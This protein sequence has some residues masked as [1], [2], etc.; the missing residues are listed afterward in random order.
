MTITDDILNQLRYRSESVDLDFKQAQYRFIGA[1]DHEKSELLKD[2]LA[3]ANS[4][5]EGTGYILIGFKDCSPNPAQVT[6]ISSDDHIDDAQL[7]QFVNSKVKPAL[8]FKYE[9]KMFEEK[10]VAVI[11]I[12]KQ[13]RPFSIETQY[14]KVRSNVVYVRRGSATVEASLAE[15]ISMGSAESRPSDGQISIEVL[16]R[17][18]EPQSLTQNLQFLT[19]EEIPNFS[20]PYTG[21]DITSLVKNI[22]VAANSDYY[23][24]L[25]NYA[26]LHLGSIYLKFKIRNQS[27][28]SLRDFK[29]EL[30]I[31]SL[32]V[33]YK[34]IE[35]ARFPDR[36]SQKM[37][38]TRGLRRLEPANPRAFNVENRGKH[39]VCYARAESVLLG[40]D[41]L[42]EP[43][44]L[45][46]Q[47]G[48]E[49]SLEVRILAEQLPTPIVQIYTFTVTGEEERHTKDSLLRLVQG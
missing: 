42:S 28:Y 30:H 34:F 43:V 33:K 37:D 15:A 31:V 18:N 13:Q 24:E 6:G 5:R 26:A 21:R 39:Q 45:R 14:G 38:Y 41:F 36:P 19:F 1:G 25:A 44:L 12:P 35:Q 10:I 32:D 9:E 11:S 4:W 29:L 20:M 7:Q 17:Q 27:A 48:S 8:N 47:A 2:I 16:N 40:E 49:V 23:R 3:L 22:D 46:L